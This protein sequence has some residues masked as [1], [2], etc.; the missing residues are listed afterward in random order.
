MG[1]RVVTG[2]LDK[3]TY[4]KKCSLQYVENVSVGGEDVELEEASKP[5]KPLC[6][7][8]HY[9]IMACHG[10]FVSLSLF[11]GGSLREGTDQTK[12]QQHPFR[13]KCNRKGW[14]P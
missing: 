6:F 12:R 9:H 10:C 2:I 3:P 1:L 7:L 8:V 14:Q 5:R 4:K 13:G 11:L